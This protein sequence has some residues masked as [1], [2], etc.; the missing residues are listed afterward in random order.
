VTNGTEKTASRTPPRASRTPNATRNSLMARVYARRRRPD[1]G[2]SAHTSPFFSRASEIARQVG[3]RTHHRPPRSG[4]GVLERGGC[5]DPSQREAPSF[6]S[7]QL[8]RVCPRPQ[9]RLG[10][11]RW[12]APGNRGFPLSLG[13]PVARSARDPHESP[14]PSVR[15]F[16]VRD[17][18]Q[19]RR[20]PG[21]S[22]DHPLGRQGGPFCQ[23][24]RLRLIG[25]GRRR[26][27]EN[28]PSG[29]SRTRTT[30]S[31]HPWANAVPRIHR[32]P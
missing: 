24:R 21:G 32:R 13:L 28:G 8:H 6:R 22:P 26:D 1:L 17:A 20:F 29:N 5:G 19:T 11:G 23:Y 4:A 18:S 7:G 2:A 10:R 12:E 9:G 25:D 27:G 16:P 14:C 31:G 3:G 30:R 15:R